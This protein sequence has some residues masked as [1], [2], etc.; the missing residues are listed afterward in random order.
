[1]SL[2]VSLYMG[3]ENCVF[4]ANITH[5]LVRMADEAGL[6]D[7]CWHPEIISAVQAKDIIPVLEK[8]LADLKSRPE[9]FK[10]FDA[11]NRWG[12]YVDFI[13]WVESYLA[14]CKENPDAEIRVGR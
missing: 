8:G 14:A 13:P 2:D 11:P 7:A 6:Y 3:D 9:Y 1:M 12:R 10:V 4:E 5:N